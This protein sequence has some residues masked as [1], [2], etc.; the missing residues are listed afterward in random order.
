MRLLGKRKSEFPRMKTAI[1]LGAG[2]SLPA[3][4][5]STQCLTDLVLSGDGVWRHTDETFYIC[6][7]DSPN[8]TTRLAN[9]MVQRL[10][11]EA[12]RYFSAYGERPANYEDLFYLAKQ[13]LDEKDGEMENPAIRAF[14]DELRADLSPLVVAA[15]ARNENPYKST[16]SSVPCDFKDL[17][18]E[19]CNYISD[20]V[21][22]SLCREPTDT[23]HLQ[24]FAELCRSGHVTSISTLCHDTHVEKF[25]KNQG[26][27]LADGF[28]DEEAGVRYWNGELSSMGKIPFLKLHGS[29]D[30]FHLHPATSEAF[31]FRRFGIPLGGDSYHTKT[32]DGVRQCPLEGR[33]LLLIGTFNKISDY[34]QGMFRELHYSF[35]ST[36]R[37]ADQLV[38]C[39]YSFGDKGINSEIIEW[40]YAKRGRRFV[41]IHPDRVKLIT[42]ARSAIQ[43]NWNDWEE[44]GSVVFIAK[45]LED[46]GIDEF[47]RAI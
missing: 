26:I 37:E 4:F 35:R 31:G 36:I 40:Y 45:P 33:P 15:N 10:H 18:R 22:R 9:C 39:G 6:G 34:G 2:S 43:K 23:D 27:S 8:E 3:G 14:V 41:I 7:S 47:L 13:A 29:I 44:R 38:V 25:L 30:W 42:N 12:E 28:S 5:P 32:D 16:E 46:V 21:W 1:L 11:A 20:I 24:I 17:V 19:T